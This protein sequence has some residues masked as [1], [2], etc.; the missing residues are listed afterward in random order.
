MASSNIR[1]KGSYIQWSKTF[2]IGIPAID[3]EHKQ[4]VALCNDLHK[5]IMQGGKDGDSWSAPLVKALHVCTEYVQTHFHHEEILMKACH[6]EGYEK[7]KKEHELFT[8]KVLETAENFDSASITSALQFVKFLYDW[9]LSHIA[10]ED[11]LISAP[12]L[13]YYKKRQND[14][15]FLNAKKLPAE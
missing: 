9:I 14:P 1:E 5:Q 7:H 10:H 4:L 15:D 6:Y 11:K 13:E 12:V 3:A 2:E 8:K